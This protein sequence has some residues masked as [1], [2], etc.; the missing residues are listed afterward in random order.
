[1]SEVVVNRC[2]FSV[3]QSIGGGYR[4]DQVL[5]EGS[6][7]KVFRVTGRDASVYAL[8]LLK[9][10]EIVPEL[11]KPL[12]ARFVMEFETGRIRSRFLVHSVAH[13]V[14]S[15][16]P[17]IVMEFCPKGNLV[18]YMERH[19]V[20]LAKAGRE[21]LCGLHDLHKNGKVHR[22]LKPENVLIREDG[23]AALTDFGICGDRNKRMTER[24]ILG[25][26]QQL[27]GTYAYMPP[28][29]VNRVR[30]DA[31]VLPTTDIFSFGVMM[32]QLLTGKLPFGEL[33]DHNDLVVYQR[34]G[35]QGHWDRNLLMRSAGGSEWEEVIAGC[36]VPDFKLRLQSAAAVLQR[37]PKGRSLAAEP[38][39][40]VAEPF[41]AA[42]VPFVSGAGMLL[43]VMQGWEY[44][45]VYDLNRLLPRGKRLL[46]IGRD[47]WN[48]IRIPEE[49]GAYVSRRHCTIEADA[50]ANRW[51]IRDGQWVTDGT[52]GYWKPSANGTYVNAT[53]VTQAGCELHVGDIITLG[54]VTFRVENKKE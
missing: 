36:L 29:Q 15:G 17:F 6:F 25:R 42:P 4:V 3:G 35:K 13:G 50:R 34:N 14:E 8:K 48:N 54:E 30:G 41:G 38:F 31:T 21:I 27:F 52:K 20:D 5:G 11:R 37:M 26:P 9:L 46:T 2:D 16:N 33:N 32:Y 1:M 12:M 24:N 39:L 19:S 28:E 47:D 40:S 7:G 10:W 49:E 23:T 45:R 44:G 18:Q 51:F 53:P 43:R 22:D